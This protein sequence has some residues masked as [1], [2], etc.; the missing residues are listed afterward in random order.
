MDPTEAELESFRQK[1]R[2][3]VSAKTKGKA[4]AP[5]TALKTS[6]ASSS[7]AP[8]VN[9]NAPQAHLPQRHHNVEELDEVEP[10]TYQDLGKKLHGKRLDETSPSP[11]SSTKEPSSALEHYE[12]AVEK[13][14]QGSLG[15]SVNL[16]RKAFRLDSKVHETYKNKHFPASSYQSHKSKPQAINPSNASVTVPNTAHHSLQGLPPPLQTLINEFSNLSIQGEAAPTDLSPPPPCPISTIPEEML[17]EILIQLAI[18]DVSSFVRLASVC[19]RLAYLVTTEERV[20]KRICLGQEFGFGAMH[21]TFAC[22][23]DGKP[24]G[25][26]GEGGYILGSNPIPDSD[27]EEVPEQCPT[28]DLASLTTLLVPTLYPTFRTLFRLRPRI[29]FNGCYI[30]TVNYTRPGASSV[31]SISWNSPIHIVTY[32]RYLRFLRDGTCISLLT[33]AEPADVVPWLHLEYVHKNHGNLPSAPMKDALLGRWRISGPA[34]PSPSAPGGGEAA[35][36]EEAEKEGTL[37]IETAGVAPKY[38]YKMVLGIGT[39]GRGAKNNKLVWQ[40]YW[41]YNRLTDDWA[42]FGLKNDRA[43]YWSRVRSYGLGFEVGA[44][45]GD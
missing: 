26:D 25:D 16:Y 2:E 10:H 12:R 6:Q 39:A 14:S 27:P 8:A 35:G 5:T 24:L 29:R 9:G 33:T 30:S 41:S 17:V 18:Q 22:Q 13:E 36:G 45:G 34:A 23:I 31:T 21:Y 3:E 37:H 40:G 43:Y 20:W 1:W 38:L 32:Y 15:D 11:A 44:S 7:K 19:K 28:P 42:E 4:P